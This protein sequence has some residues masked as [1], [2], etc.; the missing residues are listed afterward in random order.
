MINHKSYIISNTLDGQKSDFK[1]KR[2]KQ[3][4][5]S[6]VDIDLD[7]SDI[8]SELQRILSEEDEDYNPNEFLNG[9]KMKKNPEILEESTFISPK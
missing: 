4:A 9:G 7:N 1:M 5:N 6:K 8:E 3:V 2:K